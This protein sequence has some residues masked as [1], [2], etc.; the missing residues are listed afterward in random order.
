MTDAK[1]LNFDDLMASRVRV[2]DNVVYRSFGEETLLLNLD[3]GQYHGL[4]ETGGRLLELL[5]DTDGKL[6]EA[7][8][9]LAG[10]YEVAADEIS[11]DLAEFCRDLAERGLVEVDAAG[12]G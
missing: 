8:G 11:A 2:S 4:N 1:H 12:G 6:G 9:L 3:T 10:E 7:L 5:N